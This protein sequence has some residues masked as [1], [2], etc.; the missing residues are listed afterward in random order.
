MKAIEHSA[1]PKVELPDL[2]KEAWRRVHD[3]I[4]ECDPETMNDEEL[5][6]LLRSQLSG[7]AASSKERPTLQEARAHWYNV[8][9]AYGRLLQLGVGD[10]VDANVHDAQTQ[11]EKALVDI[12]YY[13]DV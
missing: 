12:G 1:N 8:R 5:V 7:W 11:Y 10:G 3:F 9:K 2:P 13:E 6:T 4:K